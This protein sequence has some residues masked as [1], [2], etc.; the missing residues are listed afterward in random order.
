MIQA[1]TASSKLRVI[2]YYSEFDAQDIRKSQ[3]SK[4]THAIVACVTMNS[5]GD[6]EFKENIDAK[7]KSM[8]KKS[9]KLKVM[10]SIGGWDNSNHFPSV[11]ESLKKLIF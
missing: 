8:K 6:L 9:S 7:L 3:L 5:E 4:L 2:G 11:M 1:D 10:M